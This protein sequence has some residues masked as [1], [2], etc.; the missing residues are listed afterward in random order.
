VWIKDLWNLRKLNLQMAMLDQDGVDVLGNLPWLSTL[1]LCLKT[2]RQD[3]ELHFRTDFRGLLVLE[4]ACIS[5]LKVVEFSTVFGG[6]L[7]TIEL[8]KIHCCNVTSLQFPGLELLRSIKE[9]YLS[10]SYGDELKLHLQSQIA[11][12]EKEIEPLSSRSNQI[13]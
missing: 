10:G 7:G 13:S 9:V 8:L 11:M 5:R 1:S 12:H 2:L 3:G 4:I 6:G